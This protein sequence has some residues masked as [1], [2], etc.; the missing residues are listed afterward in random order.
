MPAQIEVQNL[1]KTYGETVAVADISFSVAEGEIFGVIGPNGAGKTTAVE[2]IMGLRQPDAGR[3]Q[4]LGLDP[5]RDRD[6]VIPRIGIQLQESSLAQRIKVWEA[7]DLFSSFYEHTIPW[8][9]LLEAWGLADKRNT[10][11]GKLSGGQKQRLFI[12]LA[13]VNDPE[14]VFLD[15][16]TSGLDPQARR[17]AWE[18]IKAIRDQGKTVVLVTHF[19][20]EAEYLCDRIA[21]IDQGR[22]IALDT[23]QG[24]IQSL[25]GEQR[26]LFDAPAGFP[27]ELMRS[28]PQVT[29]VEN[30]GFSGEVRGRGQGFVAAVVM[31]L[32]NRHIPY[33]NLR[34][35]QPDLEDVFL[36]LTGR[37]LGNDQQPTHGRRQMT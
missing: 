20:D 12:V 19:M 11:F 13:L 24:L 8:E 21:I 7:L 29:K 26:I 3:I 4:V 27:V 14:V 23:P 16:L 2:C 22:V 32:E 36:S 34:T 25:D 15:E 17:E 37:E 10:L 18:A 6:R 9:P 1:R 31:A 5:Q 28:I 30:N 33:K 35:Q